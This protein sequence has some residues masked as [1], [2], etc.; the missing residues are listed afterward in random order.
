MKNV[1]KYEQG[2]V[3]DVAKQAGKITK[4]LKEVMIPETHYGIIPGTKKPTLFKAGAEKLMVLFHLVAEIEDHREDLEDGHREYSAEAIISHRESGTYIA[5]GIGLCSTME[6]RYRY[7]HQSSYEVLD[8]PIPEDY[9]QNKKRYYAQGFGVKKIQ[10]EWRW[11]RYMEAEKQE[12]PDIA[13][14]YNTVRK[15]AKKRA[16]VDGVITAVAA[17]DIFAQQD[18]DYGYTE[19]NGEKEETQV[20][21]VQAAYIKIVKLV[22]DIEDAEVKK[23]TMKAANKARAA[24]DLAGLKSIIEHFEGQPEPNVG[25]PPEKDVT[26]AVTNEEVDETIDV[27]V[28]K[29]VEKE[30]ELF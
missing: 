27:I 29:K 26:P 10:N 1:Q 16:L 23:Q 14:V 21:P 18:D 24:G 15:M 30:E 9:Q 3:D 6:S 7:R 2:S 5:K 20:D 13:D 22:N 4:L 12:N 25:A 28:G 19:E 17:S 8:A 11:V